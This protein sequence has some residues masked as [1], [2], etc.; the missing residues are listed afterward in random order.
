MVF[1]KKYANIVMQAAEKGIQDEIDEQLRILNERGI[2]EDVIRKQIIEMRDATYDHF[3]KQTESNKIN[4]DD[5]KSKGELGYYLYL[6]GQVSTT[7]ALRL[8]RKI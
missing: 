8:S 5:L 3:D 7:A 2:K 4:V 6:L 1:G